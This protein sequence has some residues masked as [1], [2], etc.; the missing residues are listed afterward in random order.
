MLGCLIIISCKKE[1][2]ISDADPFSEL[3]A[4]TIVNGWIDSCETMATTSGKQKLEKLRQ[5]LDFSRLWIE[6]GSDKSRLIVIPLNMEIEALAAIK[7]KNSLYLTVNVNIEDRVMQ[8][9]IFMYIPHAGNAE[10]VTKNTFSSILGNKTV[11]NDG[12]FI[13]LSNTCRYKYDLLYKNGRLIKKGTPLKKDEAEENEKVESSGTICIDWWRITTHYDYEGNVISEEREYLGQTC[14]GCGELTP[15][16]QTTNCDYLD[17][18]PGGGGYAQSCNSL[19]NV[20][21][22]ASAIAEKESSNE[23]GNTGTTRYKC[24]SWKIYTVSGGLIPM[25]L[26]SKDKAVQVKG[27]DDRWRFESLTHESIIKSGVEI[28]YSVAIENVTPTSTISS[29]LG[30]TA[31]VG[32][33]HL[34]YTVKIS[35]VCDGLPVV[36]NKPASSQTQ[37]HVNE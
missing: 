19:N 24:Y 23:C 8:D 13:V 10:T 2:S 32:A 17:D 18:E 6:T 30:I 15:W 26:K 21:S 34:S 37:W 33:M 1:T 22:T 35:A 12:Q 5:S 16:G 9:N 11:A 20:I 3:K 4:Q 7:D 36:F 31:Q 25:F 14:Y 29:H 28:L 27:Q